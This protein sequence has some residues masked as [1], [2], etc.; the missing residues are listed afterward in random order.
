MC[1]H[2]KLW[3]CKVSLNHEDRVG[4]LK[5]VILTSVERCCVCPLLEEKECLHQ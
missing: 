3:A 1:P 5:C 4:E 2:L